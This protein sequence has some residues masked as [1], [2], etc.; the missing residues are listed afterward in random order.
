MIKKLFYLIS[1]V[2]IVYTG[3][4][5]RMRPAQIFEVKRKT[6]N[7]TALNTPKKT[8]TFVNKSFDLSD[9]RKVFLLK[10]T[11]PLEVKRKGV[12]I[13][14][15]AGMVLALKDQ[16]ITGKKTVAILSFANNSTIKIFS[17]SHFNITKIQNRDRSDTNM[18]YNLFELKKGALLVDF[19]NQAD[20]HFLE[21]ISPSS[22][23]QIR[24]TQFLYL[25]NKNK[26]RSQLA[27]REGIVKVFGVNS[28]KSKFVLEKQGLLIKENAPLGEVE[29]VNW[30]KKINWK[31][32]SLGSGIDLYNPNSSQIEID[33]WKS[34]RKKQKQYSISEVSKNIGNSASK[35]KF[36]GLLK[37]VL[38]KVLEVGSAIAEKGVKTMK[39]V[40]P[41]SK[42]NEVG[43]DVQNFENEQK[44]KIDLIDSLDEN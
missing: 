19:V 26:N 29:D 16:V 4:M 35:S 32:L 10:F 7:K 24:G 33:K 34:N 14:V 13:D 28:K 11:G 25:H 18:Q 41:V 43:Q 8:K 12:L 15:K 27:V 39:R 9:E 31:K 21:I 17:N 30:V 2:M 44:K 3:M 38:G 36:G 22:K 5:M 40:N 42:I 6:S 20:G 23:L 1:V 37:S